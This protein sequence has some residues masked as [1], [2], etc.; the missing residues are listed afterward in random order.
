MA[1][2]VQCGARGEGGVAVGLATRLPDGFAVLRVN[3]KSAFTPTLKFGEKTIGSDC[4]AF[5][6]KA[7]SSLE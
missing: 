7:R 2:T 6:S 3:Q 1:A 4:A 5:S